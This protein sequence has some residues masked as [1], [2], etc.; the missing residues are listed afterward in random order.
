MVG[1]GRFLGDAPLRPLPLLLPHEEFD[2]PGPFDTGIHFDNPPGAVKSQNIVHL[3]HADMD[4][5]LAELLAAHRVPAA[6]N[7]D[8]LV[9]PLGLP[10]NPDEILGRAGIMDRSDTR[11]IEPG[12]DIIQ[13]NFRGRWYLTG[14]AT[15]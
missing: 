7:T 9:L 5:A 10:D 12:V 2:Q 3:L 8:R 6:G 4:R 13:D 14:L 1:P 15:K 11:G